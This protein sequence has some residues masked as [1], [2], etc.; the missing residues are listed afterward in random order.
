MKCISDCDMLLKQVFLTSFAVDDV[1]LYLDTHPGDKDALNYY[2]YVADLRKKAVEAYQEQ[3]GPLMNDGVMDEN[4]W[5]W[6]QD[7]W[8]WEGVCG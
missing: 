8:P 5:T 4:C 7:P 3:C 6:L 1:V 2:Y